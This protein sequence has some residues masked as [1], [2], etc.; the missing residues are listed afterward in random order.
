[1]T[2]IDSFYLPKTP[3]ADRDLKGS[4]QEW[5]KKERLLLFQVT[6]AHN[7][8]VKAAALVDVL[9]KLGLLETVENDPPRAAL[10][11]VVPKENEADFKQQKIE[12]VVTEGSVELI[13]GIGPDRAKTMRRL[14]LGT[15]QKALKALRAGKLTTCK[16]LVQR[17]QQAIECAD[18]LDLLP[19]YVW[20]GM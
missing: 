10:V 16:K 5:I 14:R 19:Q 7:H 2:A 15:I 17:H 12:S 8:P 20:G 9:S 4:A 6:V 13:N 11:F 1:M 3:A 18:M